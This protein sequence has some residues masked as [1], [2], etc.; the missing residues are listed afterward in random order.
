VFALSAMCLRPVAGWQMDRRGRVPVLALGAAIFAVASFGYVVVSS[1]GALLLLRVFHGVGM[2]L[3]ATAGPVLAGDLAPAGRRGEAIGLQGAAQNLASA[4]GPAAGAALAVALGH[5]P[6]FLAA[7][8]L[9]AVAAVVAL[10]IAEPGRGR[11]PASAGPAPSASPAHP[12]PAPAG[13][14]A[15]RTPLARFYAP[16]ALHPA[17][18]ALGLHAAYGAV[19]SFV[20]IYALRAGL[21]NPGLY[22][23]VFALAMICG[24]T[25]GG[26]ASDRVGRTA[27]I[28][29]GLLLLSAGVAMLPLLS[30]W[31][32]LA[33]ALVVGLGQGSAQPTIFALAVDR[34]DPTDRGVALGTVGTLLELGIGAGS[35]AAGVIAEAAGLGTMFVALAVAPLAA[36]ILALARRSVDAH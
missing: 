17:L 19:I 31:A 13:P 23:L 29:P 11:D 18:L 12:S 36:A 4:V 35:I 2:G 1:V 22:F 16:G 33:S 28:V 14:D 6:L 15:P 20:P 32:L 5:V 7:G 34:V 26:W 10:L 21:A 25:A 3:G 8:G 30:G 27:V 24:Q 9:A